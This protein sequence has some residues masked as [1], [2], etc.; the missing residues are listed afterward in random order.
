MKFC[1]VLFVFFRWFALSFL[2]IMYAKTVE[3]LSVFHLGC[4]SFVQSE[5]KESFC[6]S[7]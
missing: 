3:V 4:N 7:E 2:M 1:F 6:F 5:T